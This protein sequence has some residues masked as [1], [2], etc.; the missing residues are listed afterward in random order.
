[1]ADALFPLEPGQER[2]RLSGDARRIRRQEQ[3]ILHGQHPLA[4]AL[5][6]SIPLHLDGP[7]DPLDRNA[8]GLRC[9]G[10][11]FRGPHNAG[12]ATTFTKCWWQPPGKPGP[13]PR[14]SKGPGTD[15]RAW[16][17]ACTEYQPR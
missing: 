5:K 10:C 15:V 1:M 4:V 12:T 16:W 6:T 2:P 13:K 7:A 11:Q 9:G 14:I 3:A 17:P 8:P